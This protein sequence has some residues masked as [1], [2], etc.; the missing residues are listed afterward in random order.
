MSDQL[1]VALVCGL[2]I[3]IF[4]IL[5]VTAVLRPEWWTRAAGEPMPKNLR[6]KMKGRK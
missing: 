1:I 5:A 2:P 3:A 6:R 4:V